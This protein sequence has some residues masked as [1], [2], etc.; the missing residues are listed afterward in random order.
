MFGLVALPAQRDQVALLIGAMM[1]Q[2]DDVMHIQCGARRATHHALEAITTADS[3]RHIF[4]VSIRIVREPLRAQQAAT[5]GAH[6]FE[7]TRTVTRV[8]QQLSNPIVKPRGNGS[9]KV[10]Q[11]LLRF[12]PLPLFLGSQIPL[13][14]TQ[15]PACQL[16]GKPRFSALGRFRGFIEGIDASSTDVDVLS[17]KLERLEGVLTDS[18]GRH[19]VCS[20]TL[21]ASM[22][23]R[24][25]V[26]FRR[27]RFLLTDAKRLPTTL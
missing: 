24:C 12:S 16:F 6:D 13:E 11:R 7:V 15:H 26:S 18:A 17:L 14:I 10:G 21:G 3:L 27:Q 4:P 22:L 5:V 19:D 8:R 23:V 25:T 9:I 1:R 2:I 20:L